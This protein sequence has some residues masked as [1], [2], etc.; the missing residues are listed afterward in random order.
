MKEGDG[1]Y[2]W[3]DSISERNAERILQAQ[4]PELTKEEIKDKEEVENYRKAVIDIKLEPDV[5]QVGRMN[6]KRQQTVDNYRNA[7]LKLLKLPAAP[8]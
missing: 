8:S 6:D 5:D 1:Y 2:W 7:V 3:E 4:Y